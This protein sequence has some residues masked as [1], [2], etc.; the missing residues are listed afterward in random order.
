MAFVTFQNSIPVPTNEEKRM[1]MEVS[2]LMR[3]S[4]MM[5][6]QKALMMTLSWRQGSSQGRTG[7][8]GQ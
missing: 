4:R 7:L 5:S 6:W 8:G 3:Y 1:T 2:L